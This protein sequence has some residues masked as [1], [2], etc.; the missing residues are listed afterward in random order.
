MSPDNEFEKRGVV[1]NG[2]T[3]PEDSSKSASADVESLDDHVTNRLSDAAKD[4]ID[5]NRNSD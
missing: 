1:E 5:A 3:V 2:R 4:S